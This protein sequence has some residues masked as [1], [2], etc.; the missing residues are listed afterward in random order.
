LLIIYIVDRETK[1]LQAF[2]PTFFRKEEERPLCVAPVGP[3]KH[4][5][6]S[7]M[8]TVASLIHPSR[9]TLHRKKAKGGVRLASVSSY[10]NIDKQGC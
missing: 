6:Y 2:Q 1:H 3:A 8:E 9:H 5:G 4:P 7:E 10:D